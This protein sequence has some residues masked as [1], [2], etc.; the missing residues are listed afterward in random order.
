MQF[1][2]IAIAISFT[3]GG[4]AG[5]GAAVVAISYMSPNPICSGG[6]TAAMKDFSRYRPVPTTGGKS[7]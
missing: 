5:A 7:F 3:I 4:A 1:T 6:D 2:A